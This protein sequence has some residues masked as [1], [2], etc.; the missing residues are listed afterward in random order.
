MPGCVVNTV[1]KGRIQDLCTWLNP[2][3]IPDMPSQCWQSLTQSGWNYQGCFVS[4]CFQKPFFNLRGLWTA[5]FPSSSELPQLLE[6]LR[7][8][9]FLVLSALPLYAWDVT[10][11]ERPYQSFLYSSCCFWKPLAPIALLYIVP[12]ETVAALLYENT[13]TLLSL[14]RVPVEWDNTSRRILEEFSGV[15]CYYSEY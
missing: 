8:S 7:D 5:C 14:S 15:S 6:A 12:W 4:C 9:R 11:K 1:Q 10:G 3:T 2:F 13:V